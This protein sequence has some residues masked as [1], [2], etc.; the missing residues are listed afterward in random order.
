MNEIVIAVPAGHVHGTVVD[1]GPARVV[2][3]AGGRTRQQSVRN[4]LAALSDSVEWVLVH[5]AARAL[6][7]PEVVRRVLT[8]LEGGALCVVPAI[9]PHDSLR[10]LT[11]EGR[12]APLDRA[13]VRLVQTPQ[14]FTVAA[15]RRGHEM[16][17]A[18]TATDDATLVESTG[19]AV[20]LVEGDP[21]AFKITHPLDLALAEALVSRSD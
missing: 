3:V 11:K 9:A 18:E 14:G 13:E 2:S 21:R 19:E 4:A 10:H 15:L 5:D 1:G 12:N 7:P 16:A 8:A 20:T 6:V 17:E